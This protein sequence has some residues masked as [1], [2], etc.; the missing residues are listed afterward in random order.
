MKAKLIIAVAALILCQADALAQTYTNFIR[1]VQLPTGVEWDV[2][3][4]NTGEQLSPLA[5]D[6]GGARFE[7]WT[8]KSDPLTS[9]MLDTKYVGSYVPIAQ[10]RI[11]SDDPYELIP[12][13]RADRGF[14]VEIT[15]SGLLSGATDPEASKSVNLFRHVQSYGPN[16]TG[17]NLN[18]KNATLLS[19][20]S[21]SENGTV[22][23]TYAV[24]AVPGG[25]RLKVR[26][27][28]RF[29][30]FSLADYQAPESQLDSQFIQVWPVA[31]ATIDGLQNGMVID[32]KAPTFSIDL[33]D[34]YPDS[35]TY[36]QVYQGAPRLGVNGT[37]VPGSSKVI[38]V[39]VPQNADLI[40]P[41][42]D[43]VFDADGQWTLE[44]VTVTPF[45]VDR[46]AYVT[47]EL[48]R[49]ITVNGG[50]TSRE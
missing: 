8:V 21:I 28:E 24:T 6:P 22:T 35:W 16:G 13:T 40:I 31:D 1:Q 12:R 19:T 32:G 23:L 10:V 20:A 43:D 42:W 4:E 49:I 37:I 33:N 44:V 38:D 27:E 25:D 15:V 5:I 46:L 30:V 41:D 26:G 3:V 39:S 7:L 34:L 2:T 9:Y 47:L 17:V 14:R 36:A 18:R 45:G 11:V 48:D 50:V 29:S